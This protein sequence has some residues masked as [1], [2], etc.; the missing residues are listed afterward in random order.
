MCRNKYLKE[1][2]ELERRLEMITNVNKH[3]VEKVKE[4][5]EENKKLKEKLKK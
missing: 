3:L 2:A 5:R 4:L 1:I